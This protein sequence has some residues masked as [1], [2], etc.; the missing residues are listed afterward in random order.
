MTNILEKSNQYFELNLPFVLYCK[1]N[2]DKLVGFFQQNSEL[3]QI[4]NF[5][6][7]GFVFTDFKGEKSFLFPEK[8]CEVLVEA[9]VFGTNKLN[10]ERLN[11]SEDGKTDF[12]N[13]VKK[14]IAF[15]ETQA[16]QKVVLSRKETL[17]LDDFNFVSVFQKMLSAYPAA[18]RYCWFHPEIGM[19]MGATPEQLLKVEKSNFKT[20]A[21]AGTQKFES[22][23]EVIWQEKERQEQQFVTD[24]ICGELEDEVFS[25]QK[26]EPY[27]FRA[28]TIVHLKT[29]ID[30]VFNSDFDL[31]KV[32]KI[33]HPTPA[34]C[35]LPKPV[36]R[37]F[38][39][40]NEG[41]DRKFYAGFL[42]ELNRNYG[43]NENDDSD[44]YVNL[45]CMEIEEQ[46]IHLYIG[47]GI[48]K[49]SDPEKEY[50]ETANKAMTMM[51]ILK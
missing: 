11:L 5:T 23:T 45:R 46:H 13:L 24:F 48:T 47:C 31:G 41:Y 20:V 10:S 9:I 19:W 29:D 26:S 36:S 16:V 32:L 49:D 33:L 37:K 25:L 40:E 3:H 14:G 30:G 27:T 8:K 6:E 39:L 1:P 22:N 18:L 34:V 4:N 17:S 21:L 2:S 44:I 38:I 35:G 12:E 42:G 28:G 50:L 15:I 43:K 7:K 51:G